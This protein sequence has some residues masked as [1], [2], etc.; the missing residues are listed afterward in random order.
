MRRLPFALVAGMLL[1]ARVGPAAA[2][3]ERLAVGRVALI[4]PARR[5]MVLADVRSGSRLRLEV[6]PETEVIVCGTA[7]GL[8]AV[9]VGA[10]VRVKY[11]DKAGEEPEARSVLVLARRRPVAESGGR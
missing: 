1:L 3:E 4:E 5:L 2:H 6:N 7:T 9:P 8:A 11:L 10:I